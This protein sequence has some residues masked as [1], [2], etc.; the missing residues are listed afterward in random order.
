[1]NLGMALTTTGEYA[2]AIRQYEQALEL[3]PDNNNA[4]WALAYAHWHQGNVA[5]ALNFFEE[6]VEADVVSAD[7]FAQ[8][9]LAAFDA[10]QNELGAKYAERANQLSPTRLW[11][12]RAR[13]GTL[14]NPADVDR[15]ITHFEK[16]ADDSRFR[17]AGQMNLAM[18]Y[19]V[20]VR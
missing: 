12:Q 9:A 17:V 16:V 5:T 8:F 20:A 10:G 14:L 6:S 15:L 1:M 4:Y 19:A 11:S 13:W 18:A 2:G 7:L 3:E